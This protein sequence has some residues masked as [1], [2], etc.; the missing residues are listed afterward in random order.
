MPHRH[1]AM[2]VTHHGTEIPGNDR[3]EGGTIPTAETVTT[4]LIL[5]LFKM[6][7]GVSNFN[8]SLIVRGKVTR[9]SQLVS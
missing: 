8:V 3:G 1:V 4:K 9:Q 6:D 2:W 7:S 5:H